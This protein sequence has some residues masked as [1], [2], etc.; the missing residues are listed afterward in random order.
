MQAHSCADVPALS[1]PDLYALSCLDVDAQPC[2]DLDADIL[3]DRVT[4]SRPDV[5]ALSRAD[6][7][8]LHHCHS[9]SNCQSDSGADGSAHDSENSHAKVRMASFSCSGRI[10]TAVHW[11]SDAAAVISANSH[12]DRRNDPEVRPLTHLFARFRRPPSIARV[13]LWP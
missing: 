5:D 2:A 4:D 3:A 9:V 11:Q 6:S 8:A 12:V 1:S 13:E 7:F 10:V